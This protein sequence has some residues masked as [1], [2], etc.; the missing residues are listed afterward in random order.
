MQQELKEKVEEY[1]R[2]REEEKQIMKMAERRRK[3]IE[4]EKRRLDAVDISRL[5][6]RVTASESLHPNHVA[7]CH[8]MSVLHQNEKMLQERKMKMQL[9]EMENV[10]K[11]RRL[12][13]LR[14]QVRCRAGIET[15]WKLF[16]HFD[17]NI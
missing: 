2:H 6:Q 16:E 4:R 15:V 10:E 9:K 11:E 5:H 17:V 13:K 14:N 12:E 7:V 3:E 1:A 8:V